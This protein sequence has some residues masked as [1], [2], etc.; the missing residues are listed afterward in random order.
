MGINNM[1]I[2]CICIPFLSGCTLAYMD[3]PHPFYHEHWSK[4]GANQS[5]TRQILWGECGFRETTSKE[6]EEIKNGQMS[7]YNRW[8]VIVENSE[9]CMLNKGFK[10]SDYPKG[11]YGGKCKY[12]M[13][14]NLPSCKSIR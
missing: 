7:V 5:Q 3:A 2:F 1:R 11:Y 10:Y 8:I 14:K 9:N 6:K 4:A 13:Y 12:Y